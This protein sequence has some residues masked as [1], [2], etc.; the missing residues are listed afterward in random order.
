VCG[1]GSSGNEEV[2][3]LPLEPQ[4]EVAMCEDVSTEDRCM[5]VDELPNICSG[6]GFEGASI[7]IPAGSCLEDLYTQ[8]EG[9][10]QLANIAR[11]DCYPHMVQVT[12]NMWW[13]GG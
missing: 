2:V 12:C 8:M 3:E 13:D 6:F 4:Q 1:D 7:F 5:V 11:D 10:L 9:P